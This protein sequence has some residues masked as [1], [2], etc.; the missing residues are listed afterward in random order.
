M[1][2]EFYP[3]SPSILFFPVADGYVKED[4][5]D[6]YQDGPQLHAQSFSFLD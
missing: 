3:Q 2:G 4:Q 1:A 6:H 5:G